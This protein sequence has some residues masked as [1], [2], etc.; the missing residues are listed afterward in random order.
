MTSL[1]L[2]PVKGFTIFYYGRIRV[3]MMGIRLICVCRNVDS[4]GKDTGTGSICPGVLGIIALVL[5]IT[6]SVSWTGNAAWT[7][8]TTDVL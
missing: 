8:A 4:E 2:P 7:T 6:T 3:L 1:G 5:T